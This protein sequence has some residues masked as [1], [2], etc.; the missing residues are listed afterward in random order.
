MRKIYLCLFLSILIAPED[1]AAQIPG[2]KNI[3]WTRN[4]V[5]SGLVW[6]YSNTELDSLGPQNINILLVNPRKREIALQYNSEKNLTV[7]TQA[8]STDAVAAVNAGFFN[9]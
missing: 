5:A 6:K 3:K 4:K 9:I 8:S 1:L 7:N 2:F